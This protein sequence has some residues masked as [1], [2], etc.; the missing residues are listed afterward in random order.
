MN[1]LSKVVYIS[2]YHYEGQ[3]NNKPV[4]FPLDLPDLVFDKDSTPNYNIDKN[5]IFKLNT[6][7]YKCNSF[8][9]KTCNLNP[10][11]NQ[12]SVF[13]NTKSGTIVPFSSFKTSQLSVNYYCIS[14]KINGCGK[15]DYW[16]NSNSF[17][18]SVINCITPP[19]I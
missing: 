9:L 1:K 11:K 15:N 2:S 18:I 8:S 3:I 17:K 13:Y 14:C 10:V 4:Y 16:A 6:T 7:S 19:I 5:D 12:V